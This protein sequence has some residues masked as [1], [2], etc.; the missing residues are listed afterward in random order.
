M[1]IYGSLLVDFLVSLTGTVATLFIPELIIRSLHE[2]GNGGGRE[3]KGRQ[4]WNEKGLF[5]KLKALVIFR[6]Y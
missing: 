5:S 1:V 3:E 4:R 2:V 6:S